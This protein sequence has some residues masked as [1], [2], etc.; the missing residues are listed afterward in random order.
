[1][2]DYGRKIQS[3]IAYLTILSILHETEHMLL[4]AGNKFNSRINLKIIE[5]HSYHYKH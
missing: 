3:M 4:V 1:M 5:M 2:Y